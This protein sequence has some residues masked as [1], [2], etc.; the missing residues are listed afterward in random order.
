MKVYLLTRHEDDALAAAY[1]TKRDAVRMGDEAFG[2][3]RY[4]VAELTV[5]VTPDNIIRLIGSQG[6]YAKRIRDVTPR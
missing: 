2:R 4:R 5:D 3:G 1:R 6:G